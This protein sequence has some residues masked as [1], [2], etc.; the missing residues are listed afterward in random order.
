MNQEINVNDHSTSNN[1]HSADAC[2]HWYY[3][4]AAIFQ[5]DAATVQTLLTLHPD[6]VHYR[7]EKVGNCPQPI[8]LVDVRRKYI[9][10]V[11]IVAN[12]IFIVYG[13]GPDRADVG[14]LLYKLA[15]SERNFKGRSGC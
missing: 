10:E 11:M 9:Y 8:Y 13:A 6:L 14:R 1:S 7:D 15:C 2:E 5:G 3:L 4:D 12:D